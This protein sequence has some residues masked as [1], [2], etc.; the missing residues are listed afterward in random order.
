MD[1]KR[2]K[3]FQVAADCLNLTKAAAQLGYTQPTITIQLQTLENELGFAL[4]G[5]AGK[6]T[7]LTPHGQI[8]KQYADR[9]F[10][11]LSE[12]EEELRKL[13]RPGGSLVVAAPELYCSHYL[14][15]IMH[16]YISANPQ[17][18]LQLSSYDSNEAMKKVAAREADLGIIA[19]PCTLPGVESVRLGTED[20]VLVT[21]KER[22]KSFGREE[23]L[24]VGPLISYKAGSNLQSLVNECLGEIGYRPSSLVECLSDETIKRAV[25][26][27]TGVALLGAGLVQSELR[28]GTLVELHR[29]PDKIETSMI[30]LH[31]RMDEIN[32]RSFAE[33][34]TASWPTLEMEA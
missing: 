30:V 2:L 4:L 24:R 9:V 13:D 8:V 25:L 34:L 23:V 21:T 15:V 6:Q 19:G 7:Y 14:T 17:V 29:F 3:T 32:I 31:S 22:Y 27:Q 33:T 11:T 26:H 12:M 18:K 10:A 5:R 20:V 1:I 28:K 16:S